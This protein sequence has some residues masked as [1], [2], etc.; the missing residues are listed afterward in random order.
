MYTTKQK[1]GFNLAVES[2]KRY[3]RAELKDNRNKSLINDL[4]VDLLSNNQIVNTC[5]APNTT[6]IIGRKGTGKSTIF[7]KIESDF[8]KDNSKVTCYIDVKTIFEQNE[9][10]IIISDYLNN[11]LP[12]ECIEKYLLQR[13]FIQE[14]LKSIIE[15]INTKY[16][17][18]ISYVKFSDAAYN[19][20]EQ[21]E[22]LIKK[23]DNNVCLKQIE[24]PIIS[25]INE[26]IQN[27]NKVSDSF[28]AE[29][30]FETSL[31]NI[32]GKAEISATTSSQNLELWQKEFS[33]IFLKLFE[34]KEYLLSIKKI[35]QTLYIKHIYVL[36][37]D[38]SELE[39]NDAKVFVDSVLAPLNN[40]S[41]EFIKFKIA[42]YPERIYYG[43]IDPGKIDKVFLDFYELYSQNN[44]T[45]MEEKSIDF[46]KRLIDSRISYFCKCDISVFF[47]I[48]KNTM[49]DY[50]RLLFQVS[51][52]VPRCLGYVLFYCYQTTI[53]YNKLI[54][55]KDIE[56][57]AQI[58]YEKHVECI[59]DAT[60]K[61]L[62]SY[63]EKL[64]LVQQKALLDQIVNQL[65]LVKKDIISGTLTGKS[66]ESC[67]TNPYV[68]HFTCNQA[69][70]SL[71]SSLELNYFISKYDEMS[72]RDGKKVNV[73][74]INF[75]LAKKLNLRWGKPKNVRKYF[76][77]RPFDFN[78]LI[79]QYISNTK[80]FECSNPNCKQIFPYS[81][82]E[83][84]AL[85]DYQCPK[86]RSKVEL[87]TISTLFEDELKASIEESKLLLPI[88]YNIL[89]T[90]NSFS[91]G[92]FIKDICEELD[93][94]PQLIGKRAKNL[95]N[96]G[97]IK[98]S[99]LNNNRFLV[100][101]EKATVDYSFN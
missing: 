95:E 93:I 16:N 2:L 60:T 20:K 86:C 42:T 7:Q 29:A 12:R 8:Q 3:R 101:T 48:K 1:N 64:S 34:I 94:S 81:Y 43:K 51:M 5:K 30:G 77:E 13:T 73:Y 11:L 79:E 21:I 75:G 44:R 9:S 61:T 10:S 38:F 31:K 70:E 46:T 18:L 6:F 90:L 71:L 32:T 49:L 55:T 33:T 72:D 24:I 47:D 92:A 88:D 96:K 99:K 85:Y 14:I 58:Y 25:S 59:F 36:L 78:K 62:C 40:W 63:E 28:S 66:Y 74:A 89:K 57:A 45:E 91:N 22:N 52:N 17:D 41:E 84:F 82:K 80:N 97:L 26:K 35:L 98:R 53:N 39:I 76:I 19:V 15:S 68:S 23:I 83:S 37:D 4:Y 69:L 65:K 54:T 100:I 50:Y 56:N 67:K 27:E 87:R